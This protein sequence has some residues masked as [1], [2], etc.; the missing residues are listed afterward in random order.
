MLSAPFA[1]RGDERD[2]IFTVSALSAGAL[3][4]CWPFAM[5]K[6][7]APSDGGDP[8]KAYARR[9]PFVGAA[10]TFA[11]D[12]FESDLESDVRN[13]SPDLNFSVKD[14]LGF[15][16]RVG[17]RCHRYFSAE[18]QVEW[19]DNFDGTLFQDG[20]GEIGSINFEPIVVTAN[21][22]GYLPLWEDRLQP[23]VLLGAGLVTVK[24][25]AKDSRGRSTD[26]ETEIALR[27]GGGIDFYATPNIVVTFETDYLQAFGELDDFAY[28]SLGVGLQYRF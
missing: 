13:V 23:F 4:V 6:E 21:G 5:A 8:R 12:T 24:E 27:V 9:G 10:L 25:T 3:S 19:L 22:R 7:P 11:I 15:K 17:L 28:V 18:V 2:A 20:A 14:S 1:A 26:R 16:G